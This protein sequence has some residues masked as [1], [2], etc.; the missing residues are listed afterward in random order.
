M[1]TVGTPFGRG[2]E[3]VDLDERSPVPVGLVFQLAHELAPSHIADTLGQA[4][5]LEH[6]LDRQALDAHHLVF[7]DNTRR[8]LVLVIPPPVSDT[9]V[10]SGHL[11]PRLGTVATALFLLGEPA[12]RLCQLLLVGGEILGV[13]DGLSRREDDHRGQAQIK[14]DHRLHHR[15]RRDVFFYEDGDEVA[16]GGVAGHGDGGRLCSLGKRAAPAE[17][18]WLLHLGEGEIGAIPREGRAG[19]FGGLIASLALEDGI[20]RMP[21]EEVLEGA[22]EMVQGLLWGDTRDIVQPDIL[23]LFLESGEQGGCVSSS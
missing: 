2:R 17:S 3:P 10:E 23:R 1:P 13:A 21:L 5:V 11:E 12:L 6:V 19:V 18:Q 4:V 14:P 20:L 9:G 8:E 15:E 7:A 16:V 22:V